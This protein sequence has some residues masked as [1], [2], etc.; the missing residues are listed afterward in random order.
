MTPGLVQSGQHFTVIS[1][2]TKKE[3]EREKKD[4]KKKK[5]GSQM[6]GSQNEFDL[7]DNGKGLQ[8]NDGLLLPHGFYNFTNMPDFAQ[9]RHHAIHAKHKK[10]IF[11]D[12]DDPPQQVGGGELASEQM[13][14]LAQEMLE[15]D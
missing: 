7:D 4:T 9:E 2:N 10:R 15:T 8:Q 14:E 3:K 12:T 13:A 11:G 5:N 1:N 6:S